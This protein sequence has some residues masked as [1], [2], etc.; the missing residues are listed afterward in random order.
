MD[1]LQEAYLNVYSSEGYE[2]ITPERQAKIDRKRESVKKKED[3]AT[4]QR[5]D[6]DADKQYKRGVALTFRQKMSQVGT[7][8]EV[9]YNDLLK[10]LY[11]EGYADSYAEAEELLE[12]ISDEE[13][14]E[15]LEA[16]SFPLKPSERAIVDRIARRNRGEDVPIPSSTK[17]AKK[18]E[19]KA[20]TEPEAEEPQP[21][22]KRK[23][24]F[25]VREGYVDW[26]KGSLTIPARVAGNRKTHSPKERAG[27]SQFRKFADATTT[28]GTQGKI[29][30]KGKLARLA[31]KQSDVIQKTT[32]KYREG[33]KEEFD[34]VAEYLF[35]E[36]YADT[37]ENAEIMAENISE[38]W[39]NEI[40]EAR[41]SE[42]EG[43]GS[44]ETR[45]S[46]TGQPLSGQR[47]RNRERGAI[48]GRHFW[49]GGQ[50][51]SETKRGKKKD[52]GAKDAET[53]DKY[54]QMQRKKR[55]EDIPSN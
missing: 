36:G 15:I 46:K 24:E 4:Y 26:E 38:E 25:E 2:P 49:S 3:I 50:G 42:R 55:G 16:H 41:R 22:K 17:S 18:V 28:R 6:A 10:F 34:V 33:L 14:E 27:N 23:L 11:F 32:E 43:M 48:G 53:G 12:S 40:M 13:F 7:H 39:V 1:N 35:V 20:K 37:V 45:Y 54:L 51:G 31:A 19:P 9:S 5:R 29:G 8:E 21:R 52:K 44:P 47:A 30:R